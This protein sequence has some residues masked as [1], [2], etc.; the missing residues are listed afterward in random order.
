[1]DTI[2]LLSSKKRDIFLTILIKYALIL[3]ADELN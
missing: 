1:M 2:F 3:S